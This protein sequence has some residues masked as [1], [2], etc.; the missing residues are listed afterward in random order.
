VLRQ[1]MLLLLLIAAAA[2]VQADPGAATWSG[3]TLPLM[4]EHTLLMAHFDDAFDADHAMGDAT[5]E[6]NGAELVEEGKWGGA[7]RLGDGQDLSFATEGNLDMAAG[8]LMFWFRPDWEPGAPNSHTLLSM[9]LDGDPPGYFVLSQG[10][11]ETSGGA[12]R[13]YFVWDNQSYMHANTQAFANMEAEELAR[14]HHVA[15]TWQEG[16]QGANAIY[17][18]GGR[19]ARTMK[20][21]ITVR[22]P[23]S[24]LF[25]GSDRPLSGGRRWA[26]GLLDELV[27]L[28]YAMSGAEIA[29]VFRG[30]E[31]EWE[32]I[33]ARHWAWLTDVLAG[34]E[35]EL[36][37]D[38]QGRIL[39]SRAILD[40][41]TSWS[42]PEQI[43]EIV[44][45]IKRAGFNVYVP[46]I[47]HGRGTRWAFEGYPSDPRMTER[48]EA[49]EVDP[50]ELLI[51]QCHAQGIEVH[52]WFCVVKREGDVLPQFVEEG[53]P[54]KFFDAHRPE[55]RDFIVGLMLD[56]IREYEV[57]GVNLDF[58][59]TGGL[60]TGPLCRAEYR[61]K[62]G[63]DLEEDV[64]LR[65]DEGWPNPKIV[66]WQNECIADIVSRVATEGCAIRPDLI[67]SVDG[68]PHAPTDP[69][70]A[71]GRNEM[72]WVEAGWV[73]VVY[74]MD[75]GRELSWLRMD[76]V[77]AATEHPEA[78]VTL[79]GNYERTETG[80]VIPRE[81][82]LVAQHIGYCRR[83]WPGN[84]VGLY[85]WS[86][87]SDEQIEALRAGP[88]AE[89]AVPRWVRAG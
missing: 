82:E 16:A 80:K 45:K 43:P 3:G 4:D 1:S 14:W 42:E 74:S 12:G 61:E 31:P 7:V 60:C 30:Q 33:Q 8:T 32:A 63:T 79:C 65:T 29:E 27:I 19:V 56:V 41:G 15:L 10:W 5:A 22:R 18:D 38:D 59:R 85:L 57:D 28:D 6:V 58:I 24:R 76:T 72:P 23:T 66:Q 52:P 75:Y 20:E 46:C 62:F 21:D 34:P 51:E 50:L 26:E 44:A 71:N 35:P 81:G 11:W 64:K 49:M 87:L 13:M 73:D 17:L 84:G 55:F 89:D 69:P 48:L 47:W 2:T 70:D 77:R 83:K 68:H 37:R 67:V 25:V 54:A 53:T 86:M 88:F 78:F 40:E 39:E 36:E 9:N